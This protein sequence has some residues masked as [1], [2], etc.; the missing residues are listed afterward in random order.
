MNQTT[1]D[2]TVPVTRPARNRWRWL[3]AELLII[4]LG[5]LIA[6]AID[7]WRATTANAELEQQYLQ[8]LIADLKSTEN[9]MAAVAER[10][11]VSSDG[12]KA[13]LAIFESDEN[14]SLERI[15]TL[16]EGQRGFENPVPVMG[17]AEALV[18]TGDL[19]LIRNTKAKSEITRYLAQSRD[20]F[21]VPLYQYEALHVKLLFRFQTLLLTHG[22]S[23]SEK[24][25]LI[26]SKIPPDVEAFLTDPEAYSLTIQLSY[27]KE[28]MRRYRDGVAAES[29][30][31]RELLEPLVKA[32]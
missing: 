27:T 18:E 16:L 14:T 6:L 25:G 28:M 2:P 26:Y 19:G 32:Q 29:Q 20:F 21:L 31:L 24:A 22:I 9:Q 5:V 7:E 4:V 11:E 15:R 8:Q 23:T 12:S 3:F 10:N 13:L 17:T 1:I 30:K